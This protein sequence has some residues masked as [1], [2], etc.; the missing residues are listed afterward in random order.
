MAISQLTAIAMRF[1]DA[2]NDHNVEALLRLMS[3]DHEFI[4]TAGSIVRDR[5]A[6]QAAWEGYFEF[7][8]DY[9]VEID[10]V[11]ERGGAVVLVGRSLGTLSESGRE[12]LTVE[13]GD[14]FEEAGLQGPAI[15][16]ATVSDG[17]V[18]QWRVYEDTERVRS[19]LGL[20]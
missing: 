5:D 10:R 4:D 7:F 15:W 18:T 16:T 12:I 8:P 17:A 9:G 6:L 14:S 11:V 19:E 2:I 3:A 20:T 1:V 13:L